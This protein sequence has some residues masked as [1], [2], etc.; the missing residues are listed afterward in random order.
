MMMNEKT[1][2]SQP[3]L[4]SIGCLGALDCLDIPVPP[5]L[6]A[7]VQFAARREIRARALRRRFAWCV[8]PVAAAA[9]V[10]V[11]IGLLARAPRE[12]PSP[13]FHASTLVSLAAGGDNYH[14]DADVDSLAW[15]LLSLQG[16]AGE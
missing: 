16:F 12:N 9:V 15:D 2:A 13:F 8:S 10:A 5:E 1:T 14:E 7:A 4:D 6:R 11:M 3:S